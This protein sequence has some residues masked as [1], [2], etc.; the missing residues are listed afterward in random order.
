MSRALKADKGSLTWG[1]VSAHG[2]CPPRCESGTVCDYAAAAK[3]SGLVGC[4]A[5]PLFLLLVLSLSS[6]FVLLLLSYSLSFNCSEAVR[7]PQ[8]PQQDVLQSFGETDY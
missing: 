6:L 8:G 1:G 2:P 7:S 3:P 5:R 4:M